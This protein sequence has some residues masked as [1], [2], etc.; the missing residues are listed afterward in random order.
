MLYYSTLFEVNLCIRH[1]LVNNGAI[2]DLFRR[3]VM[4]DEQAAFSQDYRKDSVCVGSSHTCPISNRTSS[5]PSA[6][7]VSPSAVWCRGSSPSMACMVVMEIHDFTYVVLRAAKVVT[8]LGTN[9]RY[10]SS[11]S[12]ENSEYE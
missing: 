6:R 7:R 10:L 3:Y 2:K 4:G 12:S 5:I 8:V 11:S 9:T 1:L